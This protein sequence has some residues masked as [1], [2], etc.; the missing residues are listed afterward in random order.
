MRILITN[1]DGIT[2]PGLEVAEEIAAQVAGPD[3]EVWVVAPAF[4]QSGVGHCIS[5][6]RPMRVE[7]MGPRRFAV[8]GSPADCAMAGLL[9]IM[10]ETPPDLVLSGVNRG[11]NV[12]EDTLYSGTI[13]GSME[14]ALHKFRTV[15]MSQY[16]GPGNNA[17]ADPFEAARVHGPDILRKLI[18]GATWEEDG[19]YGV[20]Y[21]VNFPPVPAADVKGVKATAQ[22]ERGG[23]PF[24]LEPHVAPN[25]RRYLW[26][27]HGMGNATCA[28]GT[29]AREASEGQITVTP[30][31]ADLTARDLISGLG[32][33]LA[34]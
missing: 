32:E 10:K 15:A 31:R 20:F 21:N 26:I 29:D 5:Y 6:V 14:A 33:V 22:G 8:E 17:E 30:L 24:G 19:R 13:G 11:H 12:A 4:E 9:D 23:S 7:Q 25:G 34:K 18:N 3:G 1:D 28:P 2:A 16:Y 27:K